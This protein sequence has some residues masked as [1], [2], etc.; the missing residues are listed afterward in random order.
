[1]RKY[2]AFF[3]GVLTVVFLLWFAVPVL[4]ASGQAAQAKA[5]KDTA[6]EYIIRTDL[7]AID[8]P[9]IDAPADTV[10]EPGAESKDHQPV[11]LAHKKPVPAKKVPESRALNTPPE[12]L[13]DTPPRTG[14]ILGPGDELEIDVYNEPGL[15]GTYKIDESHV[16]SMPLI[17]EIRVQGETTRSLEEKIQTSL[18]SGFLVSPSVSIQV[19][20][21]RP[22]YILGEVRA[23]GSYDF[24]SD[25]S[26]LN[27]VA[28]A[29]GFTYR[30]DKN[31]VRILRSQEGQPDVYEEF[32]IGTPVH[33]GDII[34]VE[35]RFF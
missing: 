9:A 33:P 11:H 6:F 13:A 32:P 27:A 8:A 19:G 14:Y 22:F 25:I 26:V 2:I 4:A 31:E 18:A 5:G 7:L 30:A 21:H 3:S 29:G 24:K 12:Y 34:L 35:E 15:S 23:P 28:M 20:K 16:I 17:G 10:S 1:M